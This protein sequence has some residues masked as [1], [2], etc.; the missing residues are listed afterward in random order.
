MKYLDLSLDQIADFL[1][2]Y[3]N[4]SRENMLLEQ[5][6]LL[7][8]K[9]EQL[10]TVIAHVD[11]AIQ[12]CKVEE[13]D[14]NAFL[15]ALRRI[16]RNRRADELVVRLK[17]HADEP[18]GWSRFIFDKAELKADMRVLYAGAGI[19]NL[20]RCNKERLPKGLNVTCV[21]KHN[22]HMDTFCTDVQEGTLGGELGRE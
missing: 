6:R 17:R 9:R 15:K 13:Q 14:S 1:Q 12:E 2:L 22:T 16:V 10:N 3:E 19:G 5:K 18:R 4:I 21:D 7:E 20:W 11:G 8:K